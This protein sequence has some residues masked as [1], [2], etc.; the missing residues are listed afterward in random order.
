M[1]P[2]API[3]TCA[4]SRTWEA[5]VLGI[6]PTSTGECEWAAMNRV[7][8]ILGRA[9]LEDFAELQS[10]LESPNILV[11][12]GSGHN[13]GDA[14]LAAKAIHSVHP[15]TRATVILA[16]ESNRLK[17]LTQRALHVLQQ[18]L[19]GQCTL[20]YLQK[21][22]NPPTVET[23]HQQLA[24]LAGGPKGFD[25]GL[26]GLLGLSFQP[27][28][29]EPTATLL[30][31]VNTF[32]ALRLRAAV[33]LPS[34]IGDQSDDQRSFRADFTYAAGIPKT[35]LFIQPN[36]AAVGRIRYVDLGFFQQ[37][38]P[39]PTA[40]VLL[41]P[42]VLDPLRTFR[43]PLSDKRAFGHL[44]VLGGSRTMPGA[45]LMSV[46]AALRSGVGLVTAL[47]PESVAAAFAAAAPEAMW[48][49]W[50][51]TPSGG[52][53]LEGKVLLQRILAKASVLL[54]GPGMGHE[55][56][57][58]QLLSEVVSEATLPLVLDADAL[59]PEIITATAQR[60]PS[61]NPLVLTPHRGEF[62]RIAHCVPN[63]D[64]SWALREFCQ[65][66]GAITVLKGPICC[67]GSVEHP[68]VYSTFGGPVLARGGSGDL[69]CGLIAGQL[70]QEKRDP[71]EAICRAVA[72][73]GLAADIL[74]RRRGAVAVTSTQLLD[75]LPEALL[76]PPPTFG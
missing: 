59:H 41:Q 60:S 12:A 64:P 36:A 50:P 74:A 25:I 5:K 19:Q 10:R 27:P 44:V 56:E 23:L 68:L 32:D 16:A 30:E 63:A 38:K 66:S 65:K 26:D 9:I 6:N 58:Q 31:A 2:T 72:W 29:R 39:P 3:L 18:S 49:P 35:P 69:L 70:A 14:F 75:C 33:D 1:I 67:I 48:I 53:A 57:T 28:L 21:S 76:Q 7:G 52:L 51:E 15:G 40:S 45:L 43:P 61:A 11:L 34:G 22:Q 46:K 55:P 71:F 37:G 47:A 54:V 42:H 62:S 17:P 4:E 24:A 20:A 13:A 73:H 8:H